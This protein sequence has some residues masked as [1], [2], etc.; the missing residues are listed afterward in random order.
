MRLLIIG[1]L[2]V[3]LQS[4]CP[5][6]KALGTDPLLGDRS[7]EF[8]YCPL[9]PCLNPDSEDCRRIKYL[10]FEYENNNNE[11]KDI[12]QVYK[13]GIFMPNYSSNFMIGFGANYLFNGQIINGV[14][15]TSTIGLLPYKGYFTSFVN[16][17][18][19]RLYKNPFSQQI[20]PSLGFSI[21]IQYFNFAQIKAGYNIGINR[22]KFSSPFLAINLKFPLPF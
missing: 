4:C 1:V 21:P 20:S 2:L 9:K 16:I 10:N 13:I 19:N 15:I 12:N 22:S 8:V 18:Y 6:Y 3:F 17:D 7:G 14:N 11:N 5:P